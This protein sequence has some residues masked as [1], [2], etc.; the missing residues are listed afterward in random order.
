ME[1]LPMAPASCSLDA[2]GL[3]SQLARYRRIG[4]GARVI[5]RSPRRLTVGLA[6]AVE[7]AEVEEALRIEA[8]CCSFFGLDFDPAARRLSFSVGSREHEPALGA[9]ESALALAPR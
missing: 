7:A 8:E 3:E 5:E 1:P 2:E 4:E 6:D 9:I